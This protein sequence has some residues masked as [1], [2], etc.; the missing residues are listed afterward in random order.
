[1][2]DNFFRLNGACDEFRHVDDLKYALRNSNDLRNVVFFPGSLTFEDLDWQRDSFTNIT[3]NNVSFS[4]TD[5]SGITFR[6]CTFE[7]CLFMSTRFINCEFHNCKFIGCNPQKIEF[8]NTYIDPEVFV[9]M[10]DEVKHSNIG[11]HLFQRLYKNA[12]ETEQPKFVRTAEFNMRKWERYD[13][14][15]K[16]PGWNKFRGAC[17]RI[18]STNILSYLFVGYGLRA[19]FWFFWA[20]LMGVF[21]VTA[22]YFLW[23]CLDVVGRDDMAIKR[24][25]IDV[26]FYTVTTLGGSG[27]LVPRS[28]VGKLLFLFQAGV[29]LFIVGLSLRWLV[30]LAI[31]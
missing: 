11:I 3:F 29:G 14:N 10:I 13:L 26:L 21:W 8:I 30:R 9:G 19:K 22:N 15:Y 4:I 27:D 25:L 23:D 5:I 16:Y 28:D 1:M 12:M 7:D 2:L 17:F 20:V 24:N 18:W 6:G 31:R